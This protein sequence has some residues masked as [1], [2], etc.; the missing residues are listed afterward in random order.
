MV[1]KCCYAEECTLLV[2]P[3]EDIEARQVH[4]PRPPPLPQHTK[5][6]KVA[7]YVIDEGYVIYDDAIIAMRISTN[8]K[9]I[10]N[11]YNMIKA[12]VRR[13]AL[14]EKWSYEEVARKG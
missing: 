5:A 10:N 14:D 6:F 4:L 1:R 9:D 7:Q 13:R 11:N 8:D 12:S 3:P 2:S